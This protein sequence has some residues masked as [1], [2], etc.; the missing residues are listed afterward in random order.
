MIEI[1]FELY[2]IVLILL[3]PI[4]FPVLVLMMCYPI[5]PRYKKGKDEK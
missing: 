4:V 1:D 2:A 3:G 5:K